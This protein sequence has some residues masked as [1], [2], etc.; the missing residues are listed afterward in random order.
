MDKNSNQSQLHQNARLHYIFSLQ[1]TLYGQ[2]Y[3]PL[4][5][6]DFLVI[7]TAGLK[8]IIA[9]FGEIFRFKIYLNIE[10]P[11]SRCFT[12]IDRNLKAIFGPLKLSACIGDDGEDF[13]LDLSVG[14]YPSSPEWKD[15]SRI[16]GRLTRNYDKLVQAAVDLGLSPI[17]DED[18]YS[19][20]SSRTKID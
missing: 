20:R 18:Y 19:G 1:N 6:N 8:L 14:I 2:G 5:I 12:E 11:G 10:C 3:H 4:M 15:P 17:S 9:Q 16:I 7:E 13:F